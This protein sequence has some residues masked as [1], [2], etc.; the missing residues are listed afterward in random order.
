MEWDPFVICSIIIHVVFAW[1][2]LLF[3]DFCCLQLFALF[4][5]SFSRE[6]LRRMGEATMGGGIPTWSEEQH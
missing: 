3:Y 2:L 1:V 5:L 6:E 4:F